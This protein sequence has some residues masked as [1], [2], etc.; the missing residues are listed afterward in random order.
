[1]DFC[2]YYQFTHFNPSSAT[3]FCYTT[4]LT[5]RFTLATSVHNYMSRTS[6]LHNELGLQVQELHSLPVSCILRAADLTM[7]LQPFQ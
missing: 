1:M 3:L 6:F 4:F 7:W 5:Q 2:K